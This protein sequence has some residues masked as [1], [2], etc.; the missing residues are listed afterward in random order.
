MGPS[1]EGQR[2]GDTRRK[3]GELLSIEEVDR[4]LV[5]LGIDP[6][7]LKDQ[8]YK[9]AEVSKCVRS[10]IQ[11]GYIKLK[12]ED[13]AELNQVVFKG[14]FEEHNSSNFC[15]H[16]IDVKLCDILYQ[17]LNPC[18]YEDGSPEA[19]VICGEPDCEGR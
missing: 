17:P 4:R 13:K 19:T 5:A 7:K 6:E 3:K 8:K 14:K 12:G 16:S 9:W 2:P 11:K 18:D 1:L 10:A 15:G